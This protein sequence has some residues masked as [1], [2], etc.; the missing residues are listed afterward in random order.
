M[1]DTSASYWMLCPLASVATLV[2]LSKLVTAYSSPYLCTQHHIGSQ[3][4]ILPLKQDS[5]PNV[6][7]ALQ[8]A[9]PLFDVLAAENFNGKVGGLIFC[10]KT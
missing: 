3:L 9:R 6:T 5:T 4:G 1:V 10:L 8:H 2:S 7:H